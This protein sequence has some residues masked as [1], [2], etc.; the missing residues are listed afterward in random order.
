MYNIVGRRCFSQL[1]FTDS[2][3]SH[4]PAQTLISLSNRW[5]CRLSLK[6]VSLSSHYLLMF[7]I[8]VRQ[9]TL[10]KNMEEKDVGIWNVG[11]TVSASEEEEQGYFGS[12]YQKTHQTSEYGSKWWV[13]SIFKSLTGGLQACEGQPQPALR[14][15]RSTHSEHW[16]GLADLQEGGMA[17]TWQPNREVS[18]KAALLYWM[19]QTWNPW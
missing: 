2:N 1:Y 16:E 17:F 9:R 12:Y 3:H 5:Q 7:F 18:E 14:R 15:Y 4:K 10:W 13:E 6:N 8:S 19:T 11:D